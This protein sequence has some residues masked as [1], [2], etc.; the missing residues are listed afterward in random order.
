MH[1]FPI[2]YQ[3]VRAN[4][5]LFTVM[6]VNAAY[7]N[8]TGTRKSS[9]IGR[10]IGEA[11]SELADRK[12]LGQNTLVTCLNRVLAEK[13]PQKTDIIQ[14]DRPL[15]EAGTS[16]R[17]YCIVEVLPVPDEAGEVELLLCCATDVTARVRAEH[18][19]KKEVHLREKVQQQ[20]IREKNIAE[21]II[22]SLPGTFYLCDETALYRWNKNLE[23]LTGYTSR[24]ISRMNPLDLLTGE[25]AELARVKFQEI[26]TTGRAEMEARL[27]FKDGQSK[28]FIFNSIAVKIDDR[29]FV[30]G[31]GFDMSEHEKIEN[32][33]TSSLREKEVLLNEVHHRVKNNLAII[34]SLLSL[35]ADSVRDDQLRMLLSEAEGRVQ[36]MSMIHE[37]LYN[38][39]DFSRVSFGPYVTKLFDYIAINFQPADQKID[40]GITAR[41][42]YLD[43]RLAIPCALIINELLTNILKHAF[44]G[45]KTG[46]IYIDIRQVEGVCTILVKDDGQGFSPEKNNEGSTLGMSLIYGLTRQIEGTVSIDSDNGTAVTIVFDTTGSG[47]M[48]S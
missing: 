7:V 26:H 43:L 4:P 21:S 41:D 29:N 48:Q 30:I 38:Q 35:Q 22:N 27:L 47:V 28:P 18:K 40:F 23:T 13:T 46:S 2:P 12:I 17:V 1:A 31:T 42:V 19:I 15:A 11:S 32:R 3:I 16:E 44:R 39:K 20:L 33:I 6:E 45:R 25:H 24:E 34:C 9:V 37:M 36:T 8:I 14:H 5:P 10:G